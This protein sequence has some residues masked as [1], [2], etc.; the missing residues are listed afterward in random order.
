MQALLNHH[1]IA[2]SARYAHT[3]KDDLRKALR[4]T[5]VTKS[6]TSDVA[7]DDKPNRIKGSEA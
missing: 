2:S 7:T 5:Y 1:N 3:N 4:E 6:T